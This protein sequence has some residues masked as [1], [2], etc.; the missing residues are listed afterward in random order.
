MFFIGRSVG[1]GAASG[2]F[3]QE[4]GDRQAQ[5]TTGGRSKFRLWCP[6]GAEISGIRNFLRS[7][8]SISFFENQIIYMMYRKVG[9]THHVQ[10]V[11]L[12]SRFM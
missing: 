6:P 3:S 5:E 8:F 9:L 11:Q 10:F 7:C 4:P 2:V 12:N 1:E